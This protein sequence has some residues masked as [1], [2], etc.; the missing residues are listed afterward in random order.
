MIFFLISLLTFNIPIC[1]PAVRRMY[2]SNLFPVTGFIKFSKHLGNHLT[3]WS[4]SLSSGNVVKNDNLYVEFCLNRDSSR[5][6]TWWSLKYI[7]DIVNQS[8]PCK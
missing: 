6:V 3:C 2:Y 7:N 8:R 4:L 1:L 5:V